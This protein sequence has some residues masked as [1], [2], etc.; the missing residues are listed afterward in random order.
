MFLIANPDVPSV[1]NAQRLLERVRQLGAAGERVRFAAQPRGRAVPDSAQADRRRARTSDS[2]H[3]PERLQDGVDGA[4][5]R[6]AAGARRQHRDRGAVRRLHAPHHRS[7]RRR[8]SAGA[9]ETRRQAAVSSASRHSGKRPWPQSAAQ[10]RTAAP[11]GPCQVRRSRPPSS[12]QYAELK[13]N[14]HRKLLN[15]LNL[16][17]LAQAD[18]RRAESEI[19]SL[20]GELLSEENIADQ[21][22]ER[23]GLFGELVDDV[24]GLGPLEPLL[25][26][27]A[28]SDIL[29]NTYKNVFVER[30]GQH[31]ARD[32]H[33]P[34]RQAPDARHRPHRQR[35][36]PARGRQLADGGR[37]PAGRLARQRH[38]P[39]AGGGRSAAVDPPFSGRAPEGRRPRD[40]EGADAADARLPVA[41]RPVA[42]E[43]PDQRRHRRRQDDAA[44]RAVRA[45]SATRSASSPSRTRPSCSCT[46]STWRGSKRVRRTSKARAPSASGSSSSTRC[47]CVP[48]ASS[49]V[50]S[51]ARKRSTCCRP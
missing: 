35:R 7:G 2:P 10:R 23:E 32:G 14:V 46:R 20:L 39:A 27:P 6:R 3:V 12:R 40:A 17:A 47:V 15:R 41:L 37:P 1:R 36:R 26:D 48:T 30:G 19:R 4:Q 13:A 21:P 28:V 49:S 22:G 50:R 38:H 44:E 16:E 31:R 11:P 24:F 5:F 9:S 34:G 8:R 33:V 51:A 42:A 43:L 25:R 45:S 18:R 29:V